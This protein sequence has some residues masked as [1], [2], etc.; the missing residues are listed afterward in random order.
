M[1][2]L[3]IIGGVLTLGGFF[4]MMGS[5]GTLE[6]DNSIVGWMMLP[7]ILM[8]IIGVIS[9]ASGVAILNHT[10]QE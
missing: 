9:M 4:L 5:V 1:K 2:L 3:N 8:S 6:V 10:H 7:Y